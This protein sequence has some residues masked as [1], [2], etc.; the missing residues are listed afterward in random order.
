LRLLE[1]LSAGGVFKIADEISDLSSG[2]INNSCDLSDLIFKSGIP[3]LSRI[4]KVEDFYEK[5][6]AEQKN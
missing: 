1:K 6:R 3:Q 2:K 4:E 5:V